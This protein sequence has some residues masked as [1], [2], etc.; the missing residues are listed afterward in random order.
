MPL[1]PVGSCK[2]VVTYVQVR[3]CDPGTRFTQLLHP[4]FYSEAI[5]RDSSCI[6]CRDLWS[7]SF[8]TKGWDHPSSMDS[9]SVDCFQ[10]A[11]L[12]GKPFAF[13]PVKTLNGAYHDVVLLSKHISNRCNGPGLMRVWTN[14]TMCGHIYGD[15]CL[16]DSNAFVVHNTSLHNRPTVPFSNGQYVVE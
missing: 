15:K 4:C 11:G 13:K 16:S 12:T 14:S 7:R 2:Y 9:K 3:R 6:S 1:L 10:D 5:R 8:C